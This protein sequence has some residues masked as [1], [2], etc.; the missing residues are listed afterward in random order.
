MDLRSLESPLDI[1]PAEEEYREE[2]MQVAGMLVLACFGRWSGARQ[3]QK[4]KLALD[5][6]L[7]ARRLGKEAL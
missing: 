3:T 7:W 2:G 4:H 6:N 5:R 1:G